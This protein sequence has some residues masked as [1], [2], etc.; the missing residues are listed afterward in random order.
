[1][2][3]SPTKTPMKSS[4][5]ASHATPPKHY[6]DTYPKSLLKL[7]SDKKHL[8]SLIAANHEAIAESKATWKAS[9]AKHNTA[10]K[11]V[12]KKKTAAV[13]Y[14]QSTLRRWRRAGCY[15]D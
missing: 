14:G 12:M 11:K 13:V 1:M 3:G 9:L 7:M 15:D 6:N 5:K 2:P 4:M 8:E 10:V